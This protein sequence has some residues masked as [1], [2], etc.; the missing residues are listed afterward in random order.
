MATVK[1]KSKKHVGSGNFEY[2]FSCKCDDGKDK[3]DVTVTSGNDNQ[4]KSLAEL[5]CAESCGED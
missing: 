4:A 5:E 2:V 3:S 1:Q